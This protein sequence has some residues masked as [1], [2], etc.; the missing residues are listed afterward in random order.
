MPSSVRVGPTDIVTAIRRR[1]WIDIYR[2]S[3]SGESWRFVSQAVLDIGGNPPSMVRLND[4]RLVLTYGY[5]LKPFGI[6]A[7]ISRDNGLSWGEEIIRRQDGGGTDLGHPRTVIRPDGKLVT[8]YYFSEDA[9]KERF[10]GVTIWDAGKTIAAP[11]P[12]TPGASLRLPL[13]CATPSTPRRL[14][15]PLRFR[16]SPMPRFGSTARSTPSWHRLKRRLRGWPK[17]SPPPSRQ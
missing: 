3:D 12:N 17:N 9:A 15:F 13:R 1:R 7:R 16:R 5:R 14:R 2:S 4:G 11:S 6:R 8:V 10:I